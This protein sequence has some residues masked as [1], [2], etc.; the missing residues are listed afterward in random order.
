MKTLHNINFWA[1]ALTLVLYITIYFGMTAQLVLGPLQ[2]ILA[3]IISVSYYK[4]MDQYHKT[5][6][7][8]YWIAASLALIMVFIQW[9]YDN[10]NTFTTVTFLFVLP[11][12]IACYFVYVTRKLNNYFESL[13]S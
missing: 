2:L 12:M 3:T 1:T 11:M 6:L 13:N 4:E 5:M 10:Y 8:Y 7:R 9:I